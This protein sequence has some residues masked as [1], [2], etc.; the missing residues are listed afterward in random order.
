M[1][2]A[3]DNLEAGVCWAKVKQT[4]KS[5]LHNSPSS[6]WTHCDQPAVAKHWTSLFYSL[7]KDF[8]CKSKEKLDNMRGQGVGSFRNH[9]IVCYEHELSLCVCVSVCL[10][11]APSW[12]F[13]SLHELL[14]FL[15][16]TGSN[17]GSP[18]MRSLDCTRNNAVPVLCQTWIPF[19]STQQSPLPPVLSKHLTSPAVWERKGQ[20]RLEAPHAR[21]STKSL[22]NRD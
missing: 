12:S 17:R 10:R 14:H 5:A 19:P 22:L 6:A 9:V 21:T 3:P 16:C 15:C 8:H 13:S 11:L 20:E 18:K 7:S 1:S 2:F 4:V